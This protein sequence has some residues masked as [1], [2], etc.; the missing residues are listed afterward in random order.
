MVVIVGASS[1]GRTFVSYPVS[2]RAACSHEGHPRGEPVCEPTINAPAPPAPIQCPLPGS[3]R[4][5][6]A[7]HARGTDTDLPEETRADP[8]VRD[9]VGAQSFEGMDH[10]PIPASLCALI[11]V[12][13]EPALVQQLQAA[14]AGH[15]G[16][17]A[18]WLRQA[19]RQ[20]T[21]EGFP[22]S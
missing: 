1:G 17:I 14:A 9:A 19:M 20:V 18:A 7:C 3:P 4:C 12:L 22:Q 8:A 21:P 11:H 10:R 2:R 13:A 5:A 6:T 16:S 15:G